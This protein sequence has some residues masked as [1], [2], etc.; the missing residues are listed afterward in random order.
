[1]HLA[2]R[3]VNIRGDDAAM[4]TESEFKLKD[5]PQ[6]T[7]SEVDHDTWRRLCARQIDLVRDYAPAMYWEGFDRLK[8][9][10][11]RLPVQDVMSEHLYQLVGWRLSNAQN[12]Y[13]KPVDWFIHLGQKHFPVTDYI[14]KPEDFEFTPLP[15][16]FHEYFGHLAWM[17]LP[18]YLVVVDRFSRKYLASDDEQRLIISN[19]WWFT[20]E[21]GLIREGGKVR[22]FGAGL[23]SSPGEFQY[24]MRH[25]ELHHPFTI[26]AAAKA[27]A[28]PYAFHDEYFILEGFEHLEAAT[29][30]W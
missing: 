2:G 15:D 5:A 28:K 27:T 16:L 3:T 22:P 24:S 7:Y 14:R 29:A 23:L 20:I 10:T 26:E 6:R 25:T 13:L 4:T 18:R 11:Q 30:D 12:E 9:D 8:L 17:T 21:F 1:M 19:L